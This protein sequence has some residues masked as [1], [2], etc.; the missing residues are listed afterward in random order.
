MELV[1]AEL[2]YGICLK[3]W[4][5]S[6][7]IYCHC[8]KYHNK[9]LNPGPPEC[10]LE[11]LHTVV[12]SL[13]TE[14]DLLQEYWHKF[15][16][17]AW[18]GQED[19]R[20]EGKGNVTCTEQH[21]Q[22]EF[23]RRKHRHNLIN[24]ERKDHG[25]VDVIKY[26]FT[27][28]AIRFHFASSAEQR[29][30]FRGRML[31]PKPTQ[32]SSWSDRCI[33]TSLLITWPDWLARKLRSWVRIPL[34]PWMSVWFCVCVVL[35]VVSGLVTGRSAVQGKAWNQRCKEQ[36]SLASGTPRYF[37]GYAKISI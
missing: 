9:D 18:K 33:Y 15:R 7:R 26:L 6:P 11:A 32:T 35:C 24:R 29:N 34:E 4:R 25:L 30:S 14:S 5:D 10:K 23:V 12:S 1:V 19:M 8:S 27:R 21:K 22:A 13:I 28:Y 16:K 17:R 20:R 37:A 2:S 31:K 36:C 3:E